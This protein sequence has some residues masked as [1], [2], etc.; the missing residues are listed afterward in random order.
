VQQN[1]SMAEPTQPAIL[2][3]ASTRQLAGRR[4]R[5]L[6]DQAGRFV[7][8]LCTLIKGDRQLKTQMALTLR[9]LVVDDVEDN[10]ESF[11]LLVH[12]W[13]HEVRLA[14]DG[15]SALEAFVSFRPHAVL[16][17]IGLPGMDGW[18]VAQQIR[19]HDGGATLLV[20]VTGYGQERD[21]ARSQ[22][23]G[24]DA[25]LVKPAEPAEVRQ[26]LA[27]AGQLIN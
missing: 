19:R 20:A 12:S 5:R 24:F 22:A 16:L 13:G 26:L 14:H 25:H 27:E 21:R 9:V 4:R 8:I 3:V 7:D 18:Q 11:G 23:A 6:P 10:R 17:D 2:F 15:P 1:S